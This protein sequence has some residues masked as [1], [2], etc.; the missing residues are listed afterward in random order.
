MVVSLL[1]T[2]PP[3]TRPA[4][5][6]H[7]FAYPTVRPVPRPTQARIEDQRAW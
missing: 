3:E 7:R 2:T 4:P 6:E 5:A 1:T